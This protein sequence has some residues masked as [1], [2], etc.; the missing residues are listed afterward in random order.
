MAMEV[1]YIVFTPEESRNAIVGFIVRQATAVSANDI[2]LVTLAGDQDDPSATVQI[3]SPL[4]AEPLKLTSQNLIAAML[5]YCSE[6]RIQVPKR[7]IK[8]AEQ[9]LHGLTLVLTTDAN[10]GELPVAAT[11]HVRYGT[12][13]NRATREILAVREELARALLRADH[14]ES[15]IAQADAATRRMDAARAKAATQLINIGRVRGLRGRV[16]RWLVRYKD[17]H[18]DDRV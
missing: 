1:R 10:H 5:L 7:A 16:G 12:L 8:A 6:H 3:R 9:S 11:N 13:A 17:P 14:A 15:L 18:S 4:L 2:A